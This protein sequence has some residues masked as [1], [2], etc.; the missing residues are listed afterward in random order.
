MLKALPSVFVNSTAY[1]VES[2]QEM[3]QPS[4]SAQSAPQPLQAHRSNLPTLRMLRTLLTTPAQSS[5][6]PENIGIGTLKSAPTSCC[7]RAL[8]GCVIPEP[9]S[10]SLRRDSRSCP[11]SQQNNQRSATM[12]RKS[13]QQVCP[14]YNV[15]LCLSLDGEM[16]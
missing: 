4:R 8:V 7:I 9:L 12:I 10:G 5:F 13:T 2:P 3:P 16:Q 15:L 1:P 11:V 6:R 14:M